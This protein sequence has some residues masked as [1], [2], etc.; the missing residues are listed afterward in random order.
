[1]WS[2]A[3][4][5]VVSPGDTV[6]ESCPPCPVL[7]SPTHSLETHA[8]GFFYEATHLMSSSPDL[9]RNQIPA[10]K[11][12]PSQAGSGAGVGASEKPPPGDDGVERGMGREGE[13]SSR[14]GAAAL[15]AVL[16]FYPPGKT[17]SEGNGKIKLRNPNVVDQ[18]FFFPAS[19]PW[20]SHPPL[21]SVVQI[22]LSLSHPKGSHRNQLA[23]ES[24][25]LPWTQ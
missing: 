18:L 4:D 22:V 16:N 5:V 3:V 21:L 17:R 19:T 25:P 23:N 8:Y 7:Y 14:P 15:I 6:S 13:E 20:S 1:M 12:R 10:E 2:R 9:T 11:S 24:A